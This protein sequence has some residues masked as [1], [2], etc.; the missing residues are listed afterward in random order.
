ML[1]A[2]PHRATLP[3]LRCAVDGPS[4]RDSVLRTR[5]SSCD[6]VGC[7][8]DSFLDKFGGR[9]QSRITLAR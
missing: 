8:L 7:A 3:G 9:S 6:N 5:V 2:C 4:L 1:M